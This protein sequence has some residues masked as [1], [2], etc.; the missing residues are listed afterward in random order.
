MLVKLIALVH[1]FIRPD[2]PLRTDD[3]LPA[4]GAR[5]VV[6]GPVEQALNVEHVVDVALQRHHEVVFC[7]V[8]E[9]HCAFVA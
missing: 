3:W 7:K 2:L 5:V 6:I 8:D 1:H 9:A 4:D